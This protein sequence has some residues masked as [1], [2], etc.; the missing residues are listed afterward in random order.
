MRLGLVR[1]VPRPLRVVAPTLALVAVLA[2]RA[3]HAICTNGN[4][5]DCNPPGATLNAAAAFVDALPPVGYDQCAGF[6]NT[7]ADD[8]TEN[9]DN[10]CIE[11]NAGDMWL[12]AYDDTTGE[13]LVGAHLF[14]PQL[15]PWGNSVLGYDSDTQE[16]AGLLGHAGL[17]DGANGT[18]F[19]WFPNGGAFC[20]CFT[21]LGS[22]TC[23]DIFTA[24]AAND[25][26]LYSGGNSTDPGYEAFYADGFTKNSCPA[27][28]T[29]EITALR[30]AIYVPSLD[31]DDDDDG[32]LDVDDNCDLVPNVGQ[33]DEDGDGAGDVCDNCLGLVNVDQLDQDGDGRGNACDNC[34]FVD[35]LDQADV[36]DDTIGDVCDNCPDA[37]NVGQQDLDGDGLGDAC[38]TCPGDVLNDPDDD[39]L[40]GDVDNC[41]FASNP[42]QQDGDGDGP[43]DACDNCAGL[44]NADQADADGDGVG[45]LCDN[46]VLFANPDQADSDGDGLGDACD[47][48]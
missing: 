1:S 20:S 36:D 7:A 13:L 28:G 10:N 16:G 19:G 21:P 38:D 37:A 34:D 4:N 18:T 23:D 8:V 24:N 32:I 45:D 33:E 41:P 44:A 25:A 14:D 6:I 43:G 46:C 27:F 31:P 47:W 15:C 9:W 22:A 26:I 5:A 30:I 12:R 2:P 29:T 40:C 17:C 48:G 39:L 11:F 35:N 3:A 42:G